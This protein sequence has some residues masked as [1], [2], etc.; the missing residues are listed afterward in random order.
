[1][2][3]IGKSE[4]TRILQ[5]IDVEG[6]KV[7]DVASEYGCTPANIYALLSRLRRAGVDKDGDAG[8]TRSALARRGR[9]ALVPPEPD[10]VAGIEHPSS[11]DLF[12]TDPVSAAEAE[13]QSGKPG[14]DGSQDAATTP[15]PVDATARPAA[16]QV[17]DRASADPARSDA[18][19]AQRPATITELPRREAVASRE[20]I[21]KRGAVGPALAKK[22][23]GLAMR[24]AEGD[25]N[26]T[27][28]RS[29]EDLLGAVKPI[30]RAASRS[31]DAVWFSIQPIDLAT[32]DSEVA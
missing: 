7:V 30:L 2:A 5:L 14:R 10:A 13:I 31:P 8:D 29:L 32:L 28:F 21:A 15:G 26:L 19:G 6:R 12:D 17:W 24:T 20:A 23:F 22:G 11:V 1:M 9:I 4:H 3:R 25:E 18:P 16:R 27:P